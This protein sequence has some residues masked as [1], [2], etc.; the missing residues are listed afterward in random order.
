MTVDNAAWT[1]DHMCSFFS[2]V[3]AGFQDY[4]VRYVSVPLQRGR[5]D[6]VFPLFWV[7]KEEIAERK[8][9]RAKTK[10]P[11]KQDLPFL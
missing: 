8:A 11:L 1:F 6:T 5:G 9:G 2:L 10:L 3:S 4:T 7:E